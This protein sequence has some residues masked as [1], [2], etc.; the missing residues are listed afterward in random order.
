MT[1]RRR[2]MWLGAA[3][4]VAAIVLLAAG[5]EQLE[6]YPENRPFTFQA[7]LVWMWQ[8]YLEN[9]ATIEPN[10]PAAGENLIL[11]VRILFLVAL[12]LLPV[13]I[14][15]FIIS[16]EMRKRALREL[17]RLFTFVAALQVLSRLSFLDGGEFFEVETGDP[18]SPLEFPTLSEA[19]LTYDPQPS[20]WIIYAVSLL[21]ALVIAYFVVRL[22]W[23]ALRRRDEEPAP[24]RKLARE[25]QVAV[26]AL[27]A[28]E[29]VRDVVTRCYVEMSRVV[30]EE[31][32]LQR[33][34][35]V[36]AREFEAYLSQHGLPSAPVRTLTR[37]FETVRYGAEVPG[38]VERQQ[39]IESLTAIADACRGSL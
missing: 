26:D 4:A 37:L 5:L 31:R 1:K 38:E 39:A 6:L 17:L 36:T 8:Q 27:R 18:A 9:T 32:G 29:D 21:I 7:L 14:V 3:L 2:W 23:R 10:M 35:A 20:R 28:E 19:D 13:S 25:A 30:R 34:I 11:L 16:P 22:G 15:Y 12:I 24:L 33:G